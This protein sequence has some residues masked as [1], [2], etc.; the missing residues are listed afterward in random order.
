MYFTNFKFLYLLSYDYH[1][2]NLSKDN[3]FVQIIRMYDCVLSFLLII[4]RVLYWEAQ[5]LYEQLR[6]ILLA[7]M[8]SFYASV[9]VE[10]LPFGASPSWLRR[11]GTPSRGRP[12]ATREAKPS[13]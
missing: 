7:D 10:T 1:S 11:P 5:K 12:V 8:E 3:H 6:V 4:E 13:A 2:S 9:G